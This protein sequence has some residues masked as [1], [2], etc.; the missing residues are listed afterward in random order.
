MVSIRHNTGA[1]VEGY[2]VQI[3]RNEVRLRILGDG[4]A[5]YARYNG[6]NF[7]IYPRFVN[8]D[9]RQDP[10]TIESDAPLEVWSDGV[11]LG[12]FGEFKVETVFEGIALSAGD[13]LLA[14]YREWCWTGIDGH[15]LGPVTICH[16]GYMFGPVALVPTIRGRVSSLAEHTLL[17]Q[18]AA[19]CGLR[20]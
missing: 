13:K 12:V 11:R 8:E 15:E 3:D 6:L 18:S 10:I 1:A 4:E 9:S 7:E 19:S 2:A 20:R 17:S 5:L 14:Q 16:P